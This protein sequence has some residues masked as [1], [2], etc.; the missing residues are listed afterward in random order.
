MMNKIQEAKKQVEQTKS[1]LDNKQIEVEKNG[2]KVVITG[3]GAVKDIQVP[4]NF[5]QLEK[6]ELEDLIT[7]AVSEAVSKSIDLK[8]SSLKEAAQ[9]MLPNMPGMD[10]LF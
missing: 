3:N 1:E 9:G 7:L 6:E 5:Q 10:N 2:V 4:T 8:E